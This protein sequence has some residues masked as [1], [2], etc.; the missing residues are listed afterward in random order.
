MM[1]KIQHFILFFCIFS[2]INAGLVSKR[3][4]FKIVQLPAST[5]RGWTIAEDLTLSDK[6]IKHVSSVAKKNNKVTHKVSRNFFKMW[7]PK[8][9]MKISVRE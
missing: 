4:I 8:A 3:G 7:C 6:T 1:L 9:P 5:N 2:Q